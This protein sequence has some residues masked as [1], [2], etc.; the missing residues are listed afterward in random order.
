MTKYFLSV[1]N[2]EL[3][4]RASTVRDFLDEVQS[5]FP[6]SLN[7]KSHRALVHYHA[8]GSSFKKIN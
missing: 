5:I 2:Q 4:Q 8:R 3:V 7:V 6:T 1:V